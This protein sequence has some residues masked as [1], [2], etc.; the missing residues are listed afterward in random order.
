M[1]TGCA[2]ARTENCSFFVRLGR[3]MH[4]AGDVNA[5]KRV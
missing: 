1:N 3:K 4:S 2:D 5:A